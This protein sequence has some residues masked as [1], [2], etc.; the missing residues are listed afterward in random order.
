LEARNFMAQ[1]CGALKKQGGIAINIDY[2]YIKNE[3]ANTLQALKNHK[4]CDVLEN[5]GESDITALVDFLAL[6]NIAKNQGFNSSLI[7]QAQFLTGL[8]I[9]ERRKMLLLKNPEK[10]S[11]INSAIDRLIGADQMGDLFKCL[12]IW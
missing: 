12:I 9:E 7:S 6:E 8:G 4:R 2:G 5:I 1:L 10:S 11:E 3:F